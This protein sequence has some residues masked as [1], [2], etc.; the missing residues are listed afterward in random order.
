MTT[1]VVAYIY[2]DRHQPKPTANKSDTRLILTLV[3][4]P[5]DRYLDLSHLNKKR[6][7][8]ERREDG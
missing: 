5:V 1:N 3:S 8:G 2:P 6:E 7:F 4:L